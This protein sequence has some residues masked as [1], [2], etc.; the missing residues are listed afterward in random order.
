MEKFLFSILISCATV[1]NC[2]GAD[3]AYSNP[4]A[5]VTHLATNQ[6]S[7]DPAFLPQNELTYKMFRYESDLYYEATKKYLDD[8]LKKMEHEGK[9]DTKV[10]QREAQER[11]Y[12]EKAYQ[13]S[14]S[15]ISSLI[16]FDLKYYKSDMGPYVHTVLDVDANDAKQYT[17][18]IERAIKLH[19]EGFITV[20]HARHL[21]GCF[22]SDLVQTLEEKK[23]K[24][25]YSEAVTLLLPNPSKP[26]Q[27]KSVKDVY[28]SITHKYNLSYEQMTDQSPEWRAVGISTNVFLN[29]SKERADENTLIYFNFESK[30]EASGPNLTTV[31]SILK[32][33]GISEDKAP[34]VFAI[35]MKHFN[36]NPRYRLYEISIHRSVFNDVV[37]F[38]AP[39]GRIIPAIEQ[40]TSLEVANRMQRGK[41]QFWDKFFKEAKY[42]SINDLQARVLVKSSYFMDPSKVRIARWE[43]GQTGDDKESDREYRKELQEWVDKNMPHQH[44]Q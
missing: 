25:P 9:R 40:E 3:H 1:I 5:A 37:K 39:W 31:E 36:K 42:G 2:H 38:S 17:K 6:S 34:E 13:Q 41:F 35:A 22:M 16:A 23:A 12:L 29:G 7:E 20:Y 44:N 24:K 8:S 11:E 28:L 27:Y 33:Y 26:N 30:I 15:D 18:I 14:K 4:H 19:Q 10:Y 32:N 21:P 43:N